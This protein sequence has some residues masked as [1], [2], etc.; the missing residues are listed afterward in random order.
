[1]AEL[2]SRVSAA[3]EARSAGRWDEALTEYESALRL[4]ARDRNA[5]EAVDILRRI[6]LVHRDRG[7]YELALESF[8]A[9]L[10]A[11]EAHEMTDRIAAAL[12]CVA[13]IDQM[14]G[15]VDAAESVYH[16]VRK[17]TLTLGDV[18]LGA[19]VNQNL[20]VLANVRG[21]VAGALG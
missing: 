4:A 7:H 11:A 13:G 3:L 2:A 5:P 6:G 19:M 1:M 20:G 8:E 9:S 15:R 12:I 18:R 17:L 21:D 14:C 16:R 10:A